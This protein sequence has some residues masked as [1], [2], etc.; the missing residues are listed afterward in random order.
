MQQLAAQY[1]GAQHKSLAASGCSK[2]ISI[3]YIIKDL[4]DCIQLGLVA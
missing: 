3:A 4:T 2:S 1:V